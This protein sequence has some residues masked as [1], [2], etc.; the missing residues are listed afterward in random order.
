MKSFV[1]LCSLLAVGCGGGSTHDGVDGSA[2]TDGGADATL[3]LDGGAPVDAGPP[4]ALPRMAIEDLVYSGAFR[5]KNGDFGSSSINYAVGA[6]AFNAANH[7]LFIVGH[8]QRTDVAEY[9]VPT[10]GMQDAVVDLPVSDPP[11]QPF[12]DL[13][14]QA[15]D[16]NTDSLDRITGMLVVD[17]ALIVNA[18]TWYD[19]PGDNTYTSLLVPDADD[20]SSGINGV[21]KLDGDVQAGGYMAPIP[22]FYQEA[23]GGEYMTGWSSVYSIVSRY[24]VGPS[25]W[26]F[27]PNDILASPAPGTSIPATA[28]LNFPYGDGTM[29]GDRAVEYAPQ[30][31]AGPFPPASPLWNILSRGYYGFIVPNTRTFAVL[32]SAGG[33]A[34]G[35]GY[36][37]VQDNG[38]VCG[39]PCPY[40]AG[41]RYNYYWFFDVDEILAAENVYDP[42][43]YAYGKWTV[44]FEDGGKHRVIG[45]SFDPATSTLYVALQG[46]AQV[47]DYDRPPLIV[48]FRT[49]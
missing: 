19:A 48:T 5:L 36:K 30:G 10:P 32:G 16:G 14:G 28:F 2:S 26:V 17:G 8:A 33:L 31:T 35:I 12:V 39:G 47:G 38:N 1:A 24:S 3:S 23:L 22:A 20:L 6:L 15:P 9:P 37:A 25:L 34:N 45:A 46:A 11:L 4:G 42:R 49:P 27:D 13:L 7:S 41:D 40:T 44:P 18:E 43:P 21:Y 29:L